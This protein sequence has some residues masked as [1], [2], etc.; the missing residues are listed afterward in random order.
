VTKLSVKINTT[1]ALL[2]AAML[3][4]GSTAAAQSYLPAKCAIP[5]TVPAGA[6]PTKCLC[7]L[8]DA[9]T[10]DPAVPGA[11]IVNN[12]A[13]SGS[14]NIAAGPGVV[15]P[16][17]PG[18]QPRFAWDLPVPVFHVPDTT[19]FPGTD[20]YVMGM[21]EVTQLNV[22][23]P[24]PAS[25]APADTQWLGLCSTAP[26]AFV[27]ATATAPARC[28]VPWF[29]PVWGY[30]QE[31]GGAIKGTATYPS[32]S[33][34]AKKGT[35]VKVQW[36]NNLTASTHLL[37]PKPQSSDWPCAIDRTLMGTLFDPLQDTGGVNPFGTKMQPD[38]AMVVHLH[39]G[40]VPPDSDGFA[41]LWI[42][43]G[44]TAAAYG[45][46]GAYYTT[47][48][49]QSN[50]AGG[51]ANIEPP[52]LP[53]TPNGIPGAV[54]GV[55][56]YPTLNGDPPGSL[57]A[58]VYQPTQL[59]RPLSSSIFYN[60]PMVQS[61]ATIW[62]H[63]HT[64]GKTR[65]NVA[66]GPAGYFYIQE[67]GLDD[68]PNPATNYPGGT[69][70]KS[71]LLPNPGDCSNGGILAGKCF[72]IPIVFQDRAFNMPNT[73][74]CTDPACRGPSV[75]EINYP[76]GLGQPVIP[77][78]VLNSLTPG[79][80][81]GIHPQWVPEY[82]GDVAVVNGVVWPKLKVEPRPYR[83]RLLDGSNARCYT[84]NLKVAGVLVQ[85]QMIAIASDQGYLPN[86]AAVKRLDICPGERYEVVID[87]S[88]FA[89]QQVFIEN[90]AS[91]PFP[92][93]VKINNA[94][95][96]AF[97]G[98]L[99]RFDVALAP[100]AGSPPVAPYVLP[101]ALKAVT[102]PAITLMPPN[103]LPAGVA[104]SRQMVLNEVLDP[105]TLAPL[106]VQI[107]GKR[108]EDA[109]TE[110]PSRG[111]TEVWTFVNT[112]VDAHPMHLHLVQF[113]VVGRQKFDSAGYS[114]ATGFGVPGNSA[115]TKLPVDAFLRG[116]AKG[117]LAQELGFK[118]TVITYPGE[119]TTVV[120][121]WDGG[122]ADQPTATGPFYEPV[123]AGPYV[124]HCHIVDHED[125]E[126][127]R[128]LLVIP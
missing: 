33:F 81:P 8:G 69:M 75:A 38:N 4:G 42:G 62:Y 61:A 19:T 128:P 120:A 94:T 99:V 101:K 60:Y 41:E 79:V 108:F 5:E 107:D 89:G 92:A 65:I 63:D 43:N 31:N 45:P 121:R 58:S 49:P 109:L 125:N 82:F 16:L 116:T 97:M 96:F 11:W 118:D 14:C 2:A 76:N 122:W 67:P 54:N 59:Q 32:M 115:F 1:L 90:T 124:W 30:A 105:V 117:P 74:A 50:V 51:M 36:Q 7:P 86:A 83:F 119:I 18:L 84:L 80:N 72:D 3:A 34:L 123:T 77:G 73:N 103:P 88:G 104:K 28:N 15:Q 85:P 26:G 23:F 95:P 78:V 48:Y 113:Q 46:G 56:I 110:N 39:G 66:A 70:F 111:T 44:A 98:Q 68:Y 102:P 126:M 37:C 55:D 57:L 20:Y 93:G 87:F 17:L 112:T 24:Q 21:K 22:A 114:A 13:Q 100:A 25:T 52:F 12:P 40:E 29:T 127:M 35:P 91:A 6:T 53:P 64:L 10:P 9:L 47:P 71:G 27:P 106:R